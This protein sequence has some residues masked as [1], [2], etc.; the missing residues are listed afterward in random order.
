MIYFEYNDLVM[1]WN[2]ENNIIDNAIS[3]HW[4]LVR[5][6]KFAERTG[7]QLL[8]EK[9]KRKSSTVLHSRQTT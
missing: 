1:N 8:S 5:G 4:I 7:K 9:K 6:R 2:F 3:K